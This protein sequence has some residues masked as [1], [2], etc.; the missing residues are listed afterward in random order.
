MSAVSFYNR[1]FTAHAHKKVLCVGRNYAKGINF[2]NRATVEGAPAVPMWFDKPYCSII[3]N[4]GL[5][6]MPQS[7][8]VHHEVEL[9]LVWG[10]TA[11]NVKAD[12]WRHF[13]KGY[14]LGLDFTDRIY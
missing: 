9:G 1:F 12:E 2:R 3:T 13:V 4:G 7:G 5:M 11:K 10:K 8:K 6:Y 14:F